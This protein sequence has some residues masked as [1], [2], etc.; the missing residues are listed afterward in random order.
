MIHHFSWHQHHRY[1]HHHIHTHTHTNT[2][3]RSTQNNE[4]TSLS[5]TK[6]TAIERQNHIDF[7]SLF[8]P[9]IYLLDLFGTTS[10]QKLRNKTNR[11]APT[12]HYA[13]VIGFSE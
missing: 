10:G 2:L 5:T 6:P 11:P 4:I 3:M 1:Y 8:R 13:F 7:F 12:V 9:K